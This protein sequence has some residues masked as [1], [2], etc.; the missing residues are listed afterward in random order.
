M[1]WAM[2]FTYLGLI[3]CNVYIISSVVIGQV[4]S[5]AICL[6]VVTCNDDVIFF[7]NL[8]RR[9]CYFASVVFATIYVNIVDR[10]HLV[11]IGK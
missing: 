5:N 11:I 3:T 7:S 6:G 2:Q 9:F 4:L 10:S 1:L 8:S